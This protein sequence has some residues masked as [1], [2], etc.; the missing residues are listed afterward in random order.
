MSGD[1]LANKIQVVETAVQSDDPLAQ[2]AQVGGREIAALTGAVLGARK[3]RIPVVLDGFICT[4]AAVPLFVLN[5]SSLDHCL[6]GHRATEPG[7]GRLL[8]AL[9]MEPLLDLGLRLGEGSG[10]VLA[11]GIVKAAIACH[12]G[13][14]TFDEAGVTNVT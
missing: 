9:A 14:A 1:A 11:A 6:A 7:H 2:L 12:A 10:A 13:M 4:A 8:E 5:R 3:A